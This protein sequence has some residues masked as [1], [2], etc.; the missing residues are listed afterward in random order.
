M[1]IEPADA[2]VDEATHS[3]CLADSVESHLDAHPLP[4]D[5]AE[6]ERIAARLHGRMRPR[7]RWLGPMV[8]VAAV[9]VLAAGALLVARPVPREET[10]VAP[11]PPAV[12]LRVGTP[13]YVPQ[14]HQVPGGVMRFERVQRTLEVSDPS[15]VLASEG[16]TAA[17]VLVAEG[18]AAVDGRPVP[19]HTWV[20]M[21]RDGSTVTFPDGVAPPVELQGADW[22][23]GAVHEQLEALRYQSLPP[24]TLGRMQRLMDTDDDRG[25][26]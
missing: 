11:M 23:E 4:V 12:E 21:G 13:A 8:V 9:G 10:T 26:E 15:V 1:P 6:V 22:A 14:R 16:P 2:L 24:R 20:V 17:V 3:S 18:D 7:R 25:G 5:E 19:E